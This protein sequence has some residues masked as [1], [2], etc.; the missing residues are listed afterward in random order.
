MIIIIPIFQDSSN[1]F[2]IWDLAAIRPGLEV[3]EKP[4]LAIKASLIEALEK[5]SHNALKSRD[6]EIV[7]SFSPSF[8]GVTFYLAKLDKSPPG[9]HPAFAQVLRKLPK[10]ALRKAYVQAFQVLSQDN[11]DSLE[12]VV[13]KQKDMK[14]N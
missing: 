1:I 10:D 3:N 13:S 2:R 5:A 8:E 9:Q 6:I 12:A 14:G 4:G 7:E 11:L